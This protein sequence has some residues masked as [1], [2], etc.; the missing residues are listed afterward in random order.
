MYTT[1]ISKADESER[2]RSCGTSG[3][4]KRWCPWGRALGLLLV[5][6]SSLA[7][8]IA[9]AQT[10]P[11]LADRKQRG[12]G[13]RVGDLELHP[14][15]SGELGFDSNYFQ[16]SGDQREL[17]G[18]RLREPVVPTLRLRV[19]P[20]LS[21]STLG[22]RRNPQSAG[23]V[24]TLPKFT[25]GGDLA[26]R[27]NQLLALG[28]VPG[29]NDRSRTFIDGD[30]GVQADILPRRPWSFGANAML[31]R[32]AQP[33]NDPGLVAAALERTAVNGG[34]DL[35]WRPGGGTL[36]WSLGYDATYLRFDDA[37]LALDYVDHGPNLKG[38]WTF[39]PQTALLY[40]GRIGFVTYLAQQ[41]R[42]V[43][44]TPMSSTLGFNGLITPRLAV[45]VQAG[46]KATFFEDQTRVV[47]YDGL[48]GRVEGTWYFSTEQSD[49]GVRGFSSFKLGYQRDVATSGIA[50][51]YVVD[52]FYGD[53]SYGAGGVF[54]LTARAGL[55]LVEHP[56][57][58]LRLWNGS[59]YVAAEIDEVRP[60]VLVSGEYRMTS[61]VAVLGTLSYTGSLG[62]N[63]VQ[64]VRPTDVTGSPTAGADNLQFSRF[65]ALVGARWFM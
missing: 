59:S 21:V 39:F 50:N 19:T 24:A 63:I 37:N 56:V 16:G 43:D 45:L 34:A 4:A 33:N 32:I 13:I 6:V 53:L 20:S 8:T 49:A 58:S 12:I 1:T 61:N 52:R 23:Q 29:T 54:Y 5:V 18:A 17:G 48:I 14:G 30:L 55:G 41:D 38:R 28:E 11:W 10:Q 40:D 25:F 51:Y 47:D 64:L 35:R 31:S 2:R 62:D 44:S 3:Q 36:E 60:D 46:W 57:T 27:W 15:V 7:S 42:L 26:L 22:A 65:V 9:S